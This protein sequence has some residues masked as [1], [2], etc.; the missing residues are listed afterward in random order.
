MAY[1]FENERKLPT[2][3]LEA[4]KWIVIASTLLLLAGFWK[5]QIVEAEYYEQ[6][7]ER[8][9]IRTIPIIA[10]RGRMLDREGRVLVDSYPSFSV[11][12]LRNDLEKVA[13]EL[14]L[15]SEGLQIPLEE[16]QERLKESSSWPPSQP[17]RIR[18][19]ASP[20]D[21]AFVESHRVDIE[22]IELGMNHRR[23][24]PKDGFLSHAIGYV[25]EAS[26]QQVA[27]SDGR[28]QP[29]DIVGKA[30]LERQYND[31]LMGKD[32]SRRAV[33]NSVG[34]EIEKL[35]Q[36]EAIPGKPIQLTIDADLQE[37][38]E[39]ALRAAGD[40]GSVVALDPRTGEVLAMA[41][42]PAPDPNKFAIRIRAE[43]WKQLNEDPDHPLLNRA[44]QAQLAPGSVFKIVMGAAML[45]SKLIPENFTTFCPGHADFYGRTF[46]CHIWRKGGHGVVDLHQA[47]VRSCDIFFYNVGK[48]LGIER[49]AHY[50]EQL[51]LGR[52]TGIDLPSEEAGLVPSEPWK[53]RVQRQKW[54]AGETISVA[55]GQGA[56]TTTPLQLARTIGGIALGGIFNQPH[57]LKD[58]SA[59]EQRFPLQENTVEK[60]TQA[61]F[62]VVNEGGGTAIASRLEGV[63][64][65]GKTGTS[66]LI[67]FEGLK[68]VRGST[69]R[70]TENAWFVGYAPRRNPE[71]VVAVLVEHGEHGSSAAA[72]IARDIIKRYYDKK[73]QREKQQFTVEFKRYEVPA[74]TPAEPQPAAKAKSSPKRIADAAQ[75]PVTPRP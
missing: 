53:Q 14:P 51:G 44:V 18:E 67:S 26:E 52:K 57:L 3:R 15:I 30:G 37:V 5:L 27:A 6:L 32:G 9:R 41:S 74:A 59:V 31:I 21:I 11:L 73:G 1:W 33:V 12:L 49:I 71:I 68:K 69:R 46:R 70:F 24:Y 63:E 58:G 40:K 22:V 62:G 36:K 66:Q 56:L 20:A 47:V 64:F 17:L 43:D 54:Y 75:P 16:L 65:C 13:K 55:I 29:G 42:H 50:A 4:C 25:G 48:R 8:N 19:E 38:A 60:M 34:K 7:A 39:S 35:D 23:R 72:P 2:G 61:M 28:Y 45:E 10:P